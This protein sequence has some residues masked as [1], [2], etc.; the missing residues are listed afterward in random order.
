MEVSLTKSALSSPGSQERRGASSKQGQR[1]WF[2]LL[3]PRRPIGDSLSLIH[4]PITRA[5][6]GV[7]P[8]PFIGLQEAGGLSLV[9]GW[10]NPGPCALQL[11]LLEGRLGSGPQTTHFVR[12]PF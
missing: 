2:V 6:L 1:N 7:K 4:L 12:T 8:D 9:V 3:P 10:E 5:P 11:V